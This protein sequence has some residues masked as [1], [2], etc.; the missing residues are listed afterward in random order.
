MYEFIIKGL[1]PMLLF[2]FSVTIMKVTVK[3]LSALGCGTSQ[4]EVGA[5]QILHC[6]YC[7]LVSMCG[8]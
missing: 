2:V 6:Y 5:Q 3:I 8:I 4:V 1:N 7:L